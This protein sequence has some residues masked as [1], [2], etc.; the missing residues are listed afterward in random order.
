MI[1][2]WN[3]LVI[4]LSNSQ[5]KT[6]DKSISIYDMACKTLRSLEAWNLR[7]T[8]IHEVKDLTLLLLLVTY[9]EKIIYA[10]E[11]I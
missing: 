1:K 9:G 11:E 5:L 10:Y 2:Q 6:L 8:S 4:Y 3:I 7:I